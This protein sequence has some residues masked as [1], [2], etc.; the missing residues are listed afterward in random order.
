MAGPALSSETLLAADIA[1]LFPQRAGLRVRPM[2]GDSGVDNLALLLGDTDVDIAFVSTGALAEAAAKDRGLVEK[3]EV[4]ARLAPQEVHVLARP[5]IGGLRDL[6]GK[7]VNFGPKGSASFIAAEALFK[8][9]GIQVE[10]KSL[11]FPAAV[12]QLKQGAIAAAVIVG[13]KPSPFVSAIPITAGLQLLPIS[14]G[15]SF[16]AAFLPTRLEAADYPNLIRQGV[17][18]ATLATGMALLAAKRQDDTASRRAVDGFV[19]RLFPRFSELQGRHPRLREVNLAATIPGFKRTP[20]AEAWIAAH[21]DPRSKS[22]KA[23]ASAGELAAVSGRPLLSKKQQEA[24]FRQFI[25]WRR[26]KER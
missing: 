7:S 3:I 4:V 13:A 20:G 22:V 21:S 2:L 11:D 25:Q 24:L 23:T 12:D 14:F 16:E 1:S 15:A 6:A 8:A 17:Q 5:E 9:L 18:V 10:A 26:D 19:A